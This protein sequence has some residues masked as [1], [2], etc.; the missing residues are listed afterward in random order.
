MNDARD[1]E[2]ISAFVDGEAFDPAALADA[3]AAADG[4]ELLIDLV[5]LR[6]LVT[7]DRAFSE[8]GAHLSSPGAGRPWRSFAAAAVV[9]LALGGG[10]V[11]GR[12]ASERIAESPRAESNQDE[13][14][15][16]TRV[17]E[18][19]PGVEWQPVMGGQR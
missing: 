2:V 6:H 12:T 4:R 1:T 11:A 5:A 13:A 17:I 8:R 10:F 14:P 18:L 3:L 9:I 19:R 15:A 16:P 7:D